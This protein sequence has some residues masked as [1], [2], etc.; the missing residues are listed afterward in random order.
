MTV[1]Y[2]L[3]ILGGAPVGRYAALRACKLGA[4]VA[5]IEP[6]ASASALPHCLSQVNRLLQSQRWL[7][8][9]SRPDAA[10]YSP[11]WTQ[12]R[13]WSERL[14]QRLAA[15]VLLPEALPH[16]VNAGVE[17]ILA[18]ATFQQPNPR[19]RLAVAVGERLLR[20]RSYLLAPAAV[21]QPPSLPEL[22]GLAAQPWADWPSLPAQ[23]A[24]LGGD[25][26]GV[27]LAQVLQRLGATVSL[28][29]SGGFL[30]QADP[31]AERLL[32]LQLE[33]DG[34][35][36]LTQAQVT[37]VRQIEQKNWIQVGDQTIET[38]AILL[39]NAQFALESLNLEAAGVTWQPD[40]I[41]VNRRL[42]TTQPRIYA[43][44]TGSLAEADLAIQNA[45]GL[46][47]LGLSKSQSFPVWS[48]PTAPEIVRLGLS[49]PQAV[50]RYGAAIQIGTELLKRS[51][52]AQMRGETTG[53]VKLIAHRDG[54][55]L[56]AHA[57]GAG[58][59][60]WM[61]EVAL[62]IP[63]LK[64]KDLAASPAL[65]PMSQLIRQTAIEMREQRPR[66]QSDLLE[67]WFDFRRAR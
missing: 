14:S 37:Q 8:Q 53:F 41:S 5:L 52:S 23:I 26:D 32:Q 3:I 44:N 58:A 64:L 35:T 11:D 39:A 51:A 45:L 65:S 12:L 56:G 42:Q 48:L 7:E 18:A 49:E 29:Q 54:R 13:R 57:V 31:E 43:C 9:L 1:D 10:L 40:R 59:S 47:R 2:D 27:W 16:L 61:G 20:A 66:W 28:I 22:R 46:P 6:E 33:A 30:P 15:S 36:V 63:H 55:I 17:V 38:E 4:R 60:D 19:L 62:A 24:I 50:Q 25:A 21:N 34:V 67:T